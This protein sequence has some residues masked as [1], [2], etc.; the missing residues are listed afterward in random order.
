MDIARM[1][2]MAYFVKSISFQNQFW[3]I[4]FYVIAVVVSLSLIFV[5]EAS[6][7]T[8]YLDNANVFNQTATNFLVRLD[9]VRFS[10][11]ISYDCISLYFLLSVIR[12][13]V[14]V[15]IELQRV[16]VNVGGASSVLVARLALLL[17][18]RL[19]RLD[20]RGAGET[21]LSAHRREHAHSR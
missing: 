4:V 6:Y 2:T 21:R 15:R 5:D 11:Y 1:Q 18:I 9:T 10:M 16:Q 20:L 7:V 19:A 17:D 8:L 3:S 13:V 12:C 14:R